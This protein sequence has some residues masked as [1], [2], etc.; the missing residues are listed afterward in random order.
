MCDDEILAGSPF[1]KL[2][3]PPSFVKSE[4]NLDQEPVVGRR[5]IARL[6]TCAASKE[7]KAPAS[8]DDFARGDFDPGAEFAARLEHAPARV[9]SLGLK[10]RSEERRV[11]KECR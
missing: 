9:H 10:I 6:L 7:L 3:A 2:T 5:V 11:G 4:E 8:G 1:S